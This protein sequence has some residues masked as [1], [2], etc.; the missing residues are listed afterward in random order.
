MNQSIREATDKWGHAI[1]AGVEIASGFT[2][3]WWVAPAVRTGLDLSEGDYKGAALNAGLA[4][5]APYAV[6]KAFQYGDDLYR[7][8]KT[9]TNPKEMYIAMAEALTPVKTSSVSVSPATNIKLTSHLQGDDA[10]RMFNEYAKG[11]KLPATETE[12]VR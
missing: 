3:L 6:G 10:A 12:N 8:Y 11:Y 9:M 1:G 5:A 2:P 4:F 7:G